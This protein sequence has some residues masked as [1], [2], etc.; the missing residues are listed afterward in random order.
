[1]SVGTPSVADSS[2]SLSND[3]IAWREREVLHE[4]RCKKYGKNYEN[5][6]REPLVLEAKH[7][8]YVFGF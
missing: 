4:Q 2:I 7:L 1:M 6:P 3:Q 5:W 8:K